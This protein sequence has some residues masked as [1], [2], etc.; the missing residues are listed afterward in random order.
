MES[1][2][3]QRFGLLRLPVVATCEWLMVLPAAVLLAA[4]ALRTLQ[5][6]QYEP[7]RTIWILLDWTATHV[8][9]LD[10]VILF[11]GM[12]GVVLITGFAALLRKWR[13]DQALRH[14]AAIMFDNLRRHLAFGLLTVAVLLGGTILMAV[15]IHVVTD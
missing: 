13:Q 1:V 4:A 3:K 15:A 7:A 9:R 11:I 5:P 8:S 6:R 10:A 2:N 12:P 14:D